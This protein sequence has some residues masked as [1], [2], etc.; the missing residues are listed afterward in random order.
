M[1]KYNVISISLEKNYRE[2]MNFIVSEKFFNYN[3]SN[4]L[5]ILGEVKYVENNEL[6]FL[7]V[8]LYSKE[9]F[10]LL[11]ETFEHNM[12]VEDILNGVENT[13]FIKNLY[14]EHLNM[15]ENFYKDIFKKIG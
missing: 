14:N 8:N 13:I 12:A 7:Q 1:L 15:L 5:N 10:E 11:K 2:K 4:I 3:Y 9:I 6:Q